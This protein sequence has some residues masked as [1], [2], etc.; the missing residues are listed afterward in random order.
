[1]SCAEGYLMPLPDGLETS[2]L[3]RHGFV[4]PAKD[5]RVRHAKYNAWRI[6]CGRCGKWYK[7]AARLGKEGAMICDGCRRKLAAPN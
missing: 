2:E 4:L 6:Q 3:V 7:Q 5:G 1:M